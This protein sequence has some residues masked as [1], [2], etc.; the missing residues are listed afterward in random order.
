MPPRVRCQVAE[1]L[2]CCLPRASPERRGAEFCLLAEVQR[3]CDAARPW[4]Q[5]EPALAKPSA[6]NIL[7]SS[8]PHTM[9]A[10]MG[11]LTSLVVRTRLGFLASLQRSWIDPAAER[12]YLRSPSRPQ[13]EGLQRPSNCDAGRSLCAEEVWNP[14]YSPARGELAE[15]W[16]L[17]RIHSVVSELRCFLLQAQFLPERTGLRPE[18]IIVQ[19]DTQ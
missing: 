16:I 3:C 17:Q 12:I 9:A 13:A 5:A 10:E 8:A 18:N 15:A 1:A 19:S 6:C 14:F 7:G 11:N 4:L 2:A